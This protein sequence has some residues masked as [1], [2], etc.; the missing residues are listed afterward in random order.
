M[1]RISILFN[2]K[3]FLTNFVASI[4]LPSLLFP[5]RPFTQFTGNSEET[6]IYAQYIALST[7]E[8]SCV[9]SFKMHLLAATWL[10]LCDSGRSLLNWK[11]VL[12]TS[13]LVS[14]ERCEF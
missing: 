6:D 14:G 13:L 5:T 12:G 10:S 11:A 1:G 8:H 3:S 2:F 7:F 4:I 9:L